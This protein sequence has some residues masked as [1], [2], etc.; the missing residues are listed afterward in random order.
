M[1][2]IVLFWI[3]LL[4]ISA[5]NSLFCYSLFGSE[6]ILSTLTEQDTLKENQTLY[7]GKVWKNMFRR[8]NGDQFL[9]TDYFL[10]GTVSIDGKTFKNL[11]IRYDI[12]S[13][14]IMIPVNLEEIVQL[15]KEMIDSFSIAFENKV[16]RFIK[17][18]EETFNGL[19]GYKG[20][21]N[22]L[23][24]KESALYIKFRKEISP[25]ITDK[26]DGEFIVAH[27]VYLVKDKIVYPI[28]TKNDLFIALNI[29]KVQIK[30]YLKSNKLRVSKKSP[31]SFIPVIRFYDSIS[32]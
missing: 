4:T 28:M 18:Q 13:D 31:E 25:D 24:N 8:V 12:Y 5:K 20:Y 6:I 26:S 15:N 17:I 23:Y 19:K 16:H 3:L 27:K 9:F 1:N 32:Q 30:N 10:P 22:V 11:L 14:E 7:S 21:F 2:R 29:E